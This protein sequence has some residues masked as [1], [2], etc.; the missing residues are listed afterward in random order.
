[1]YRPPLSRTDSIKPLLCGL[2]APELFEF[3]DAWNKGE[4][5]PANAD[6]ASSCFEFAESFTRTKRKILLC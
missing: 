3:A 4:I 6:Q 5:I 2:D 1:M